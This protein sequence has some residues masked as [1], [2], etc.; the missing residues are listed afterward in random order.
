MLYAVNKNLKYMPECRV[1]E[2]GRTFEYNFDGKNAKE[3]KVLGLA[4]SS[5]KQ[6]EKE[7]VYDVKSM[8]D[9]IIKI[10]KNVDVK[11][12]NIETVENNWMHPVNSFAVIVNDETLGYISVVHPKVRDAINPKAAIVVA[13]LDIDT[14]G[15]MPKHDIMYKEISK[16]Q[17]VNFDLS[18]IVDKDTKYAEIEEIVKKADMEYLMEYS[19]VDIYQD[20]EKLAGKKTVTVR[21]TIGSYTDTLTKEQIDAQREKVLT[22]LKDGGMYINE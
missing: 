11:Y 22:T 9:S 6:T 2:V 18:L 3:N 19:L 1:F 16:Y 21:F 12:T 8:I 14:L 15:E 7:L 20:E 4:V 17:T 13:E 5:T 10:N